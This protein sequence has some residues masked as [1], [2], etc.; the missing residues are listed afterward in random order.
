MRRE[1]IKTTIIFG[2]I[3]L[4]GATFAATASAECSRDTL[5]KLADTYIK[6]QTSGDPG[7]IPLATSSEPRAPK[8]YYGENDR[9]VN[10]TEGILA[11]AIKADFTRSLHDTAQCATFTEYVAA[12]HAHPYVIHTRMEATEEGKVKVMESVVTDQDD[13]VFGAKEYLAVT[14]AEDWSVIPEDKRDDRRAI[15]AAAE[16]YINNWGDPF[17]PVPHGTPCSRL[18]GRLST[19]ARDP[20]GQT[21]TMGAFPQPIKTGNRRYVI[22]ETVGAINIFHN[23]SWL[24]AGVGPY[25]PGIPV[26]HQFRVLGKMNRYIHEVTACITPNCG[27]NFGPPPQPQKKEGEG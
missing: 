10:I 14:K 4:A 26:S 27:R 8:P 20:E 19:A 18:E 3:V 22:D 23:F 21:C 7:L 13:W 1:K 17:L 5:Q 15:Q 11:Q 9:P 16:A 25:H 24:D 6:A 2:S 12:S